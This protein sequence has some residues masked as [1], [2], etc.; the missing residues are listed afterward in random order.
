MKPAKIYA[1]ALAADFSRLGEEIKLVEDV[2]DGVHLDVMDG[3]FVPNLSFGAPVIK[4]LRPIT[5]LHFDTQLMMSNPHEYFESFADA[6]CDAVSVH[7]EAY[8]DPTEVAALAR[9]HGLRFGLGLNP[10]TPADAIAPYLDLCDHVLA[11]TVNP[12]FGGQKF[13]EAV[14]PKIEKLR[15]MVDS[16]DLDAD[17]Q[18]DGGITA[19]T[20]PLARKAGAEAFVVGTALFRA[21]DPVAAAI[22]IREAINGT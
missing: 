16:N 13:I 11:M 18:V 22:A 12:G 6:G 7:I 19:A 4:S 5:K 10:P 15:E 9:E 20:A 14:M 21:D 8:P 2:V 3:H 17:V 1:S